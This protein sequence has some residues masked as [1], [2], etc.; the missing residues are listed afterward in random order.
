MVRST[1]MILNKLMEF[2]DR[3]KKVFVM[4]AEQLELTLEDVY[5]MIGIPR[6]GVIDETQPRC[7]GEI[8]IHDILGC[9][10][11]GTT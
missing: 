9:H 8:S 3:E 1:K 11:Y 2:Y 4:L 5:F 7:L 6:L 10:C